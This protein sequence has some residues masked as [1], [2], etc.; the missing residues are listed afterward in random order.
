M[1]AFF[2]FGS[3]LVTVV[4]IIGLVVCLIRKKKVKKWAITAASSFVI[5]VVMVSLP[6]ETVTPTAVE[7]LTTEV[8][9]ET[10]VEETTAP[11]VIEEKTKENVPTEYKSALKK[12][13]TYSDTM[14]MS[15]AGVYDQ[16]TSEYGEKFSKEAGQYAI[17]NIKADWKENALKK[18]NTYQKD[19]AM[20]PSGIYDQ[21]ISEH[22][23]KFT[24]EEAQYAIDN[25]E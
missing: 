22:G 1:E 18:A 21:L 10:I 13:N 14:S 12:A 15:K 17:D 20:S 16:L 5:F 6:T 9:A 11:P 3:L 2:G 19:M 24:V 23:E 25:L 7:P 8:A 4:A